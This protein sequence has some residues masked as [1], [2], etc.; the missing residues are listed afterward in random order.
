[1]ATATLP[2]PPSAAKPKPRRSFRKILW[3]LATSL[4]VT[5]VLLSFAIVLIFFGTLDQMRFGIHHTLE[6]YFKSWVVL[7]PVFSL[8]GSIMTQRFE[9]GISWLVIPLPGGY[10]VGTLTLIN[11]ICAHFRYFRPG[12]KRA[13]IGMIHGGIVLLIVSGFVSGWVQREAQMLIEEGQ[14]THYLTNF[15]TDEL[16]V[17]DKSDPELDRVVAFPDEMVRTGA[18]LTHPDLPFDLRVQRFLDNAMIGGRAALRQMPAGS[19][20]FVA[21]TQEGQPLLSSDAMPPKRGVL[22]LQDLVAIEQPETFREDRANITT[23]FVTLEGA[24]TEGLWILSNVFD[25][26]F[27]PQ[28]FT[29]DG[30]TYEIAL[31]FTRE[32]LP[33]SLYLED[34]RFDR[35][36]GTDIPSNFSSLVRIDDP[37]VGDQREALIYMNHPLRYGG[38]TFYQASFD[39]ETET[40]TVLQVVHHPAW[41]LPYLAVLLVGLGLLWQFSWHLIAFAFQRRAS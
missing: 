18:T 30:R 31:R 12:W 5:V 39:Q 36:P 9:E 35:H 6:L 37:A 27:P 21:F 34:F 10:L 3:D 1:M 23:A 33:F 20:G 41:I 14:S 17:I 19:E 24:E 22:A 2:D 13:G 40:A 15:R 38:L 26:R 25:D 32:Y 7:S 8:L 28:S 29:Y 11:L 16:V 4:R